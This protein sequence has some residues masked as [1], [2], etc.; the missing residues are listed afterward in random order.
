MV[1]VI[2]LLIASL[3]PVAVLYVIYTLDLYKTGTFRYILLSFFWGLIAY[4]LAAQINPAMMDWGWI[5]RDNVLRYSAPIVEEILK[6]I[7]LLYI[8]R[9]PN[10]TYFVDGAIYGFATGIGFA[11][12]ENFE[13]VLGNPETALMVAIGR[14]ISTNLIHA[15]GSG[16]IGIALG[17][18]RFDHSRRQRL[19]LLA[20]LSLAVG[21]HI[22]FNNLVTR[23][24]NG[25]QLPA[26]ALVGFAGAGFI[27]L[28]IRRG[29]QDEKAWI[30]ESLGMTDRVTSGEAA[31][32]NRLKDIQE[33]LE[34][35]AQH[36]GP[37]KARMA[38]DF[39]LMQARLGIQRNTLQKLQ[40]EKM[41]QA[42]EKQMDE[43]RDKMD[44][45]RRSVGTYC[46]LYLRNIFPEDS[47]PLWGRLDTLIQE[48]AISGA[49]PAGPSLWSS[50]DQRI[51]QP[52]PPTDVQ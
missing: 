25:F 22:G 14:V 11:I 49:V 37:E 44:V 26:A 5:S 33:I 3:I 23:I 43:L 24:N 30:E 15:T 28:A 10:F 29:L 34:P 21:L 1:A 40:D 50:L 51:K 7:I 6:G 45:I 19:S 20:G 17:A 36:F 32:V 38:E 48:R 13:Y 41:R 4:E 12:I 18:S 31:I 46:M 8:I 16:I 42:V 39:L 35:L 52:D 47:S 9:R 27:A 2:A